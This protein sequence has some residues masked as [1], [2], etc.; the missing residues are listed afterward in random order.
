MPLGLVLIFL[1]GL[2]GVLAIVEVLAIVGVAGEII[3]IKDSLVLLVLL[4]L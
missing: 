3:L 4:L 2:V 1:A